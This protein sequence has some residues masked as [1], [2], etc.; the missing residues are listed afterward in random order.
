[1]KTVKRIGLC[2]NLLGMF[3]LS[4]HAESF[5]WKVTKGDDHLFIGGTIHVLTESDY[6]LPSE[7]D[8]AYNRAALVVLETDLT[9]MNSPEFQQAMMKAF[10]YSDD[11]TLQ[12]NL[13]PETVQALEKFL[14]KRGIPIETFAKFKPA[15][16]GITI[17]LLELQRLG[18]VG[19]GVDEFF[20]QKATQD[21]KH[22]D[23]LESA[24]QQLAFLTSMGKGQEDKLIMH[25]LRDMDEM[26]TLLKSMKEAWRTGDVAKL[27]EVA[28]EPF[29]TD[30]PKLY[31]SLIVQRNNAWLPKIETMLE[32]KDIEL[33]L[34][35]ALHLVGDDGVLDQLTTRGCHV[36]KLSEPAKAVD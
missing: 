19:A 20:L 30:F 32:T 34:V 10:T 6:P 29:Q 35:G 36:E 18:L 3:A 16:V 21:E 28:L 33:V 17:T 1:M 4:V 2:M 5:L 22:V 8:Q 7:F 24:E 11:S 12:D 9:K 25:T 15:M 27:K 23:G 13:S 14:S 31:A 26:P